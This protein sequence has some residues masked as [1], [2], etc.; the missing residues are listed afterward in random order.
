MAAEK[1]RADAVR[2]TND[3]GV[4]V[5][6]LIAIGTIPG[7]AIDFAAAKNGE[8]TGYI[9]SGDN[10]N[11]LTWKAPGST[12]FGTAVVASSDGVY[13]LEDGEDD[14]KCVRV[15]VTTAYLESSAQTAP[16]YL[17]DR[18]NNEIG[19][20][21]V[22][23]D[24]ADTGTNSTETILVYNRSGQQITNLKAWIDSAV[25]YLQIAKPFPA[26][27][28]TPTSE[29]HADVLTW[30]TVAPDAYVTIRIKRTIPASTGEAPTVLNVLHL[31]WDGY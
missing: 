9:Q 22:A 20:D 4:L 13:V 8:G 21:N 29:G 11:E 15:T 14:D 7:V 6:M 1:T 26:T 23:A 10:G 18:F 28:K 30:A 12:T 17:S 19:S 25:T 5:D 24:D 31:S 16:V 27:F 3:I 2:I